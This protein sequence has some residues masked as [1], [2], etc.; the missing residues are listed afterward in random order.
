MNDAIS[1]GPKP[2]SLHW[3]LVLVLSMATFGLFGV[4][5]MFIQARFAKKL[6]PGNRAV[7][8]FTASLALFLFYVLL[9][10][11]VALT[12]ARGGEGTNLSPAANVVFLFGTIFTINGF[13]QIRGSL[14]KYYNS[15]EPINLKLSGVMT[16][17][18]NVYYL[19]YHL[20]RIATYTRELDPR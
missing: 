17:F 7:L 11:V 10:A 20:A 3:A 18:F 16:F 13:F 9:L 5:W 15:V 4:V 8:L 1:A 6:D 19:Q 2:P 12:L 14:L